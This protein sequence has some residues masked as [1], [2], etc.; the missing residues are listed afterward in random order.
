MIAIALY[1]NA[2]LVCDRCSKRILADDLIHCGDDPLSIRLDCP[3]CGGTV[4]EIRNV[5]TNVVGT[6]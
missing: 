3:N 5:T 1:V 2:V 4:I 6:F